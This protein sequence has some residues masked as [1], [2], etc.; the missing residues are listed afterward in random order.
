MT[1]KR[2][3]IFGGTTEGRKLTEYLA[4]RK[5]RVHVCVATAYGES[6]LPESESVTAESSRMDVSEMCHRIR[7]YAPA[8]VVDAT[9]PYAREV[10]RNIKQACEANG[11]PYLRLLREAGTFLPEHDMAKDGTAAGPDGRTVWVE[12]AKEATEY[13]ADKEGKIL[14]TTGS[15]ELEAFTRIPDYRER[16]LCTGTVSALGGGKMP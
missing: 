6:L 7:E 1:E 9:H 14:L 8:F 11:K 4:A 5:V 12:S 10:S 15:K 16:G 13:L 2:I 3:L